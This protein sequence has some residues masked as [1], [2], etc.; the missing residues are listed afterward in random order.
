MALVRLAGLEVLEPDAS[1][2]L[3]MVL[4]R[5]DTRKARWSGQR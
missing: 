3:G 4:A 5:L 1:E 2:M